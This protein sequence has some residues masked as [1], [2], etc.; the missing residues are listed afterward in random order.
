M[1]IQ[2]FQKGYN[3]TQF[4]EIP[5]VFEHSFVVIS[6][7]H[8][9]PLIATTL[10]DLLWNIHRAFLS[11]LRLACKRSYIELNFLSSSLIVVSV[12]DRGTL[13]L[14]SWMDENMSPDEHQ[15]HVTP[16][17]RKVFQMVKIQCQSCPVSYENVLGPIGQSRS[18]EPQGPMSSVCYRLRTD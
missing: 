9:S 6:T 12:I 15:S 18:N 8:V 13:N 3:W 1:R 10:S 7:N 16:T 17:W 2:R 11:A 5:P 4:V 14:V